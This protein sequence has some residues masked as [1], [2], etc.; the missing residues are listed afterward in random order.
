M[1]SLGWDLIWDVRDYAEHDAEETMIE[2]FGYNRDTLHND[3]SYLF[4]DDRHTF[5]AE[6]TGELYIYHA[7]LKKDKKI[8]IQI[9][10]EYF[11]KDFEWKGSDAKAILI[12]L[13]KN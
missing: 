13:H 11:G 2:K 10:E 8:I 3:V 1:L 4:Y 9:F 5:V 7:L 6:L 12:Y